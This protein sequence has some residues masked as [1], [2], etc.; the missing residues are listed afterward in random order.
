LPKFYIIQDTE[1]RRQ[2]TASVA[3]GGHMIWF[4]VV[5]D[6]HNT[7]YS[8]ADVASIVERGNMI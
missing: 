2:G 4:I 6:L 1:Y 5:T 7:E 8:R 3:D